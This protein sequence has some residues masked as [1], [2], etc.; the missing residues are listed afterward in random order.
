MRYVSEG[1]FE[2]IV[3]K[4]IENLKCNTDTGIEYFD[5]EDYEGY[6]DVVGQQAI[7][8]VRKKYRIK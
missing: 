6:E 8:N 3:N 2:H 1:K 4:E 7:Y 5:K